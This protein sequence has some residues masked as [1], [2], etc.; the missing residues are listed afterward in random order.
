MLCNCSQSQ[1]HIPSLCYSPSPS[2]STHCDLYQFLQDFV[3]NRFLDTIQIEFQE[4]MDNALKRKNT[5]LPIHCTLI[6]ISHSVLGAVIIP[7]YISHV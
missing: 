6:V 5:S 4:K 2:L 1:L 7:L 3:E